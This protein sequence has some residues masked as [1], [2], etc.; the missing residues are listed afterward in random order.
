[1]GVNLSLYDGIV[2][3]DL[4]QDLDGVALEH[5]VARE[6]VPG[7]PVPDL[8]RLPSFDRRFAEAGPTQ[9]GLLDE[10]TGLREVALGHRPSSLASARLQEAG[11]GAGKSVRVR[12]VGPVR[13]PRGAACRGRSRSEGPERT[14]GRPPQSPVGVTIIAPLLFPPTCPVQS[15]R[16]ATHTDSVS[17]AAVP[18]RSAFGPSPIVPAARRAPGHVPAPGVSGIPVTYWDVRIAL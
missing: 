14:H 5:P 15:L 4:R 8:L 1:M 6:G 11:E 16:I 12:R 3:E 10:L 18:A 9:A 13:R 2:P 7:A 17:D